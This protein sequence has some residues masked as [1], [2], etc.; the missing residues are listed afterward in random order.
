MIRN[1]RDPYLPDH[2]AFVRAEP[3][4][5]RVIVIAPTRAA[6]ETIELAVKIHIETFLEQKYGERVRALARSGRG[7]GIVAGTGTGKTLA[8]RPISEEILGTVDLR[9]GV[10]N[11]EREATPETPTWNVI[12]VTTGIARRWFEEGDILATDTIIVDEIHQTSAELEICLALGK[13][14][15]CRFVWL[16][17]TV[18][19]NFYKRYLESADVLEVYDFDPNKAATVKIV[20]KKP[21]QFLDDGFLRQLVK[22]KHGVALFVPTR[23]GVEDAAEH[24]RGMAPRVNTAFYHGGEPIRILRPFLEGGEQKPYFLAMTAAGQSALNVRGLDTVIIDDVKFFNVIDRGRN[25]LTQEHLGANE[26]LQMAGRVHGRVRGGRVFILSDRDI[27]FSTLQPTEPEFQ[28]AGDSERVAI[29]CAALGVR[30]DELELPVPL[31]RTAY[32]QALRLLEERGIVEKG[33]LTRYGRAVE[34]MP[35]ERAW[36]EL[37]VNADDELVPYLSVMSSVESLHRMTRE[38]R[39]LDGLIVPGSDHLTAYNLY[40]EAFQ[41]AGSMGEV[42]GLPRHI[43]DEER[44]QRWAERRG[45]LVK[46][47]EDAALGMASIYRAVGLEIPSRM[48]NAGEETLRAFQQLLAQFMPFTLVIDEQ[49]AGGDEARV[50]KTSVCGSWGPITGELRYFA[51]KFGNPR[52][53]IEG[54]Q[55]PYDLLRPY[56]VVTEGEL[57][58]NAQSKRSPLVVRRRVEYHGFELEREIEAV[59]EF[60]A[61]LAQNARHVLAEALARGEA[62]HPGV[63]R[64]QEAVDS[65][66]E[67]YRRSGGQTPR[68]SLAELTAIYEQQLASLD[69]MSEFRHARLTID[70][71]AI[72]PR[73]VRERFAALPSTA[74]VRDREVEIHYDVEETPEGNRG[75]ARLRLPEKL[76]RTLNEAELPTLDRPLRFIVTRGARGAAR[77]ATLEELQDEL[78]R[79]FTEKEIAEM[80]QKYEAGRRDRRERKQQFRDQ[81]KRR[82]RR[83]RDDKPRDKPDVDKLKDDRTP[84]AEEFDGRRR[85]GRGGGKRFRPPGKGRR[86]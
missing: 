17:A 2:E 15:G 76:A 10:V 46:A 1:V 86:G 12:I 44:I 33:R 72:V 50:S 54:T 41:Y 66:R 73:E 81:R 45:A 43:F 11:R 20:D 65:V 26:I 74:M 27:D 34:A 39:D 36:A 3:S 13:R 79:P 37:L 83:T 67:T 9:V 21:I 22:Q 31:D 55:I 32:G 24:V 52:A 56:A 58:Y 47:I 16:S 53:S 75:V 42:Y 7:F 71:D 84:R 6:C 61:E 18:N 19:P 30:A 28:L 49:T 63:Q 68:L 4:S 78:S 40:A 85:R 23:R 60:P 8:I 77:G 29:T 14:V 80:D 82:E 51:D 48:A 38:E 64:N 57:I 5:G 59:D 35:V 69:S 70:A 25:V 62:R